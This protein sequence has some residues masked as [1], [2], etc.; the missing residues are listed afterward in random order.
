MSDCEADSDELARVLEF[1]SATGSSAPLDSP[2]T[3][4]TALVAAAE[5]TPAEF[6]ERDDLQLILAFGE[7][8][9]KKPRMTREAAVM[10]AGRKRAENLLKANRYE[11]AATKM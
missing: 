3:D 8:H 7:P 11:Q 10:K 4:L 5:E 1:G 9:R 6:Q 2:S